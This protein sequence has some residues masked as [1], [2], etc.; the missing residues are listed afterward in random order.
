VKVEQTAKTSNL[1][2]CALYG[3]KF[4]YCPDLVCP[5]TPFS[6]LSR[7]ALPDKIPDKPG[8]RSK[9]PATIFRV[10]NPNTSGKEKPT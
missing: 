2:L 3:T 5:E 7:K 4:L 6:V 10:E 8:D 1:I 9:Q